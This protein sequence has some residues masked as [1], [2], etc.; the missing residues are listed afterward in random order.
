[1]S[2]V[3][4]GVNQDDAD[5]NNVDA[6]NDIDG[7]MAVMIVTIVIMILLSYLTNRMSIPNNDDLYM[8]PMRSLCV[9]LSVMFGLTLNAESPLTTRNRL[10]PPVTTCHYL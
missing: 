1:M 8:M 10:S 9:C 7:T 6:V 2:V 3:G 4:L 5:A